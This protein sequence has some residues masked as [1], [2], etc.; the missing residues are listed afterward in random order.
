MKTSS[1]QKQ[2]SFQEEFIPF[3][4]PYLSKNTLNYLAQSLETNQIQGDGIFTKKC[5]Q[6]LED[7]TKTQKALLTH[8]GTAALELATLLIDL[9]EGDEVIIPSYTF[10]STANAVVLRGATPIFIDIR[11]DTLNLNENLIEGAITPK[12]KAIF[13]VHYAGVSANMEQINKIAQ[14]YNLFVIEDAAQGVGAFYKG[15]PLGTLGHFGA[16]SF[17]ATKNIISGEG[18]ALLINYEEFTELAEI[19]REKGTNRSQFIRGE[20]DKYTWEEKGSS[21]L[22]S[23]LTAAMLLS[24]L[25]EMNDINKNRMSIWNTYHS[26]FESLEKEGYLT[27]PFIPLDCLHNAHLYYVIVKTPM[28]RENLLKFMKENGVQCTSHYVP[29]HSA[30]AGVKYG[31][32]FGDLHITNKIADQIVRF[33]LWPQMTSDN[34]A[35]ITRLITSFFRC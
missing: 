1:A 16:Y 34:L 28:I 10:S 11:E 22:P 3:V 24:Q 25:E 27:R 15:K 13:P 17:H 35:H 2:S 19:M 14:S 18:G 30:P 9:K 20:V 21:F 29:L 12:T 7:S 31:K 23:D 33:P 5:H 4:K 26:S 32:S 8:S 6:F